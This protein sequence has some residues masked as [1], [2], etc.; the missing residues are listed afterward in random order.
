MKAKSIWTVLLLLLLFP[1]G[2]SA[3]TYYV[4]SSTGSDDRDGLSP[5]TAWKTIDKVNQAEIKPGDKILFVR[6]G[7]WRETL[8]PKSGEEGNPI[9]YGAYGKGDLPKLYGSVDASNPEDWIE[10][11]PGIWATKKIEPVAGDKFNWNSKE[12]NAVQGNGFWRRHQEKDAKCTF[13]YQKNG[14]KLECKSSGTKPNHLQIWGPSVSNNL[15]NSAIQVVFRARCSKPFEMSNLTVQNMN[16]PWNIFFRA[17]GTSKITAEWKENTIFLFNQTKTEKKDE[18][19]MLCYHLNLGGMPS[20]CVLEF[21]ILDVRSASL[22][23]SKIL[24]WDVGNIIFN[25]GNYKKLHRCGIKKWKL[26]DCKNPG[27]YWYNANDQRVYLRFDG[28]PGK[29]LDSIELALSKHIIEEGSQ[30]DIIHENLAVAYG[31]AHGFHGAS[32]KRIT[33]RKC[34]IYY[35]GGGHQFTYP[36]G[37]P[38]RFGNG[39]EFWGDCDGNLVEE[40]RIWEIYDAALTNQGRNGTAVNLIYRKNLIWNSEY[41]YEYWNAYITEN[42]LFEDNICLDAGYGWGHDQR[43]NP[44]GA[45]LMF[46]RNRAKTKNFVVRNNVFSESTEVCIRMENDW[47]EGLILEGNQYYQSENP[48]LRWCVKTYYQKD[49]LKKIAK[50]LGMEK[51][52]TF[53][54]YEKTGE[55]KRRLI[56]K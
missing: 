38:V 53:K 54:K 2:A 15:P 48:L 9:Y 1:A 30:H 12:N 17:P 4:D 5:K 20:D 31:A 41:S 47:R 55:A 27:D 43:P 21:E 29:E 23:I 44:N 18:K 11:Q 49:E 26:K 42:I 39:I 33:I 50:E 34:D 24:F 3:A 14:F 10:V 16:S 46:Y 28:N 19:T 52:G 40:N 37:V 36:N 6:G 13:S 8:L 22:D 32:T 51:T 35:I 7:L 45:H 25:H 56:L